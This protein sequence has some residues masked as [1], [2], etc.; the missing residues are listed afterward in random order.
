VEISTNY[1]ILCRS[2]LLLVLLSGYVAADNQEKTD[3]TSACS[4]GCSIKTTC[5]SSSIPCVVN[6]K[7]TSNSASATPR[8]TDAKGNAQFCVKVGT[9]VIWESGSKNTGFILDFGQSTPFGSQTTITGGSKRP[10]SVVAKKEGC[11]KYTV[12]ACREG[13]VSQMCESDSAQI[14]VAAGGN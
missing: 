10:V 8:I 2:C 4:S 5:G 14:L 6:V 13:A 1:H 12:S 7:R 9:T 3:G 11:F